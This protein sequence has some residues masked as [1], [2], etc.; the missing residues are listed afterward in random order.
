METP[1]ILEES[2]ALSRFTT[3]GTGGPATRFERPQTLPELEEG[4]RWAANA[5]RAP[6]V[7]GLGSNLLFSDE[8]VDAVVVK[9]A[10]ELAQARVEGDVLVAG[11]GAPNAVCL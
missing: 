10:G 2:V 1:A 5:G 6:E 8:G 4:V 9:L 3:I 11:G 7:V